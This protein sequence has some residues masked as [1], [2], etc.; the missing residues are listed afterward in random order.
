M[1]VYGKREGK[2]L[3]RKNILT[4]VIDYLFNLKVI[5]DI[6]AETGKGY[7]RHGNREKS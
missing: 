4:G 6:M 1:N 3:P 7:C 2:K 5:A